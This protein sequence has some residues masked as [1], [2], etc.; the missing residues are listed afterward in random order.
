MQY[1]C[2]ISSVSKYETIII[3]NE[4]EKKLSANDKF[5][6]K[7]GDVIQFGQKYAFV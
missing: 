7:S 2:I 5:I 3:R 1:K 6:L 4:E